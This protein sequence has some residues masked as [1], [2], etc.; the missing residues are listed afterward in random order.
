MNEN[1]NNLD[2]NIIDPI[3][4]IRSK[5]K[6]SGVDFI[7]KYIEKSFATNIAVEDVK[8]QVKMMVEK[9]KLK[10]RPTSEI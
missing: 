9:E 4:V 6:R 10:N 3:K 2:G 8:D 5:T 7:F 1:I